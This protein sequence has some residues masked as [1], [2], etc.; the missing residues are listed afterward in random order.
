VR[1]FLAATALACLL[2]ACGA[3]DQAAGPP[4][5]LSPSAL[6]ELMSSA[7]TLDRDALAVDALQPRALADLLA[8]SG[9]EVGREREFSGKTKTFDH[10]VARALRFESDDGAR[11]YLTWL[12]R[13]G[14]DILGRAERADLSLPGDSSVAFTLFRCGTCKKELPTYLAGWRRDEIVLTLLAAGSGANPE[15][16]GMLV[17]ELDATLG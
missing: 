4:Q 10:V 15:R 6:P 13:H 16:F 1:L 8:E 14:H 3:E 7:R 9:F 12:G 5:T 2:A 11:A 17:E